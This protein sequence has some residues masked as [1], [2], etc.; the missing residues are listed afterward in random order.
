MVQLV[1]LV[2]SDW[3]RGAQ[4]RWRFNKNYIE[5]K[6]D[7]QL[8][9][10][11]SYSS[12]V[13]TVKEKALE[14]GLILT[15]N[16]IPARQPL[17]RWRG[18]TER[19]YLLASEDVLMEICTTEELMKI[20]RHSKALTRELEEDDEFII[21]SDSGSSTDSSRPPDTEDD[22]PATGGVIRLEDLTETFDKGEGAMLEKGKSIMTQDSDEVLRKIIGPGEGNSF[23]SGLGP[24]SGTLALLM[25]STGNNSDH[26]S[27]MFK[28]K[29]TETECNFSIIRNLAKEFEEPTQMNILLLVRGGPF[30][31]DTDDCQRIEGSDLASKDHLRVGQVLVNKEAFKL[32]MTLYAIANKFRYLHS[33]SVADH[34]AFR[35]HATASVIGG[36]MR[37]H[38]GGGSGTGP[39]PGALKELMRTDHRVPITYWKAW[40]SRDSAIDQ[41]SGS[42]ESAY[43]SLTSYLE[44][45]AT[46]KPASAQDGNFQIFPIGFAIVD[47]ENDRSWGWFFSKLQTVVPDSYNLVF[48]SDRHTSIYSA[49][50]RI[51]PQA[52]HCACLMHLQ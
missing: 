20:R 34:W 42:S 52:Q 35:N 12:F 45:V 11:E 5:T 22:P 32:H 18:A 3:E 24:N 25:G 38:Y 4:G 41:G 14:E 27:L 23:R 2:V 46:E 48:V 1:R 47:S 44:Q 43:L 13:A 37:Q 8:K 28:G 39:R 31:G 33:C 19:G 49:I 29:A 10:N 17:T 7:V 40:N 51:Y 50:R 26:N 30:N 15:A 9:E 16:P 36:I 6:Y 21:G